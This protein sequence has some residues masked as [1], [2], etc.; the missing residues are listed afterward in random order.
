[1]EIILM[2][3][4]VV[5]AILVVFGGVVSIYRLVRRIDNSIGLDQDGRT[6]TDRMGRV[7]HQLWPNGGSSLAD[8]V[9]ELDRQSRETSGEVKVILNLLQIMVAKD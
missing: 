8:K 1:M 5:G 6:V 4:A 7:E 2:V 3:G 9:N